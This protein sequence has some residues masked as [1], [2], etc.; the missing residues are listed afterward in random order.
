MTETFGRENKIFRT[1]ALTGHRELP[2]GFDENRLYDKLEELLKKGC[3][4]FL[5]GMAQGFDLTA[6][7]CLVDLKERYRFSIEACIPYEG[8]SL[9]LP[10]D[11]K[12]KYQTLL[13]WCDRKTVLYEN[14]R[15]GCFLARDRYMVDSADIVFAYCIKKTGGTAYTVNYALQKKIPVIF[16]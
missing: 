11:L 10:A 3:D 7:A 1:C 5:C 4:C 9:R 8:H 15:E 13:Q 12:K 2:L 14:Y 16:Y 6:L